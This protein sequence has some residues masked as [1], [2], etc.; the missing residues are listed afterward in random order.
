[1]A[2]VHD[3]DHVEYETRGSI[4]VW[5]ITDLAAHFESEA[6]V[7]QSEAHYREQASQDKMDGSV[8]VIENAEALGSE[9]RDTLD[10]ISDEWSRLADDV[11]VEW[12]A[13]VADG[14]IS[15]T[16]KMKISA[17]VETEAFDSVDEAVEWC[18]AQG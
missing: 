9:I 4:G 17:D 1:M 2:S 11:G 10:H 14:L 7:E 16:V 18:R 13:Y 8:V 12:H 5:T 15:N 3:L 6:D